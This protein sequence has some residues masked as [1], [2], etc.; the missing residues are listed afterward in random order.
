MKSIILGAALLVTISIGGCTKPAAPR[1]RSEAKPVYRVS[2]LD[3]EES[4]KC[5]FTLQLL[6]D[7][8]G[9]SSG[10]FHNGTTKTVIKF[11]IAVVA[12]KVGEREYEIPGTVHPLQTNKFFLP[13]Y[14]P[15]M[16]IKE[17]RVKRIFY[18]WLEVSKEKQ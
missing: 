10:I 15:D 7:R 6:T 4:R 18:E 14:E 1:T 12:D 9:V 5:D 3:A 8:N 13:T 16:T 11:R 17:F 2:E